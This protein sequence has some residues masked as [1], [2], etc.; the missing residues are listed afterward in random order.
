MTYAAAEDGFSIVELLVA[1]AI[2]SFVMLAVGGLLTLGLRVKER[3]D[4]NAAVQA[5]LIDLQGLAALAASEVGFAM[6]AV[7]ERGFELLKPR[8][9]GP[10]I[11]WSVELHGAEIELQRE[12]L[13]SRVNLAIFESA[14][15][16]YLAPATGHAE[17]LPAKSV[18]SQAL[19]VRLRLKRDR[20]VWRPLLWIG[21]SGAVAP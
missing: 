13:K 9:A 14:E 7:S 16:E 4:E 2:T 19:A 6:S 17:W 15:L 8:A 18:M 3:V 10:P 5:T 21:S 11:A 1:I 12:R 20:H